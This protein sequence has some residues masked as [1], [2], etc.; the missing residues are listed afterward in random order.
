MGWA[1]IWTLSPINPSFLAKNLT[2]CYVF[3]SF[4]SP[5]KTK[6]LLFR[7]G[8]PHCG[9]DSVPFPSIPFQ[10]CSGIFSRS[11]C[12]FS[13]CPLALQPTVAEPDGAAKLR[14]RRCRPRGSF[15]GD[16]WVWPFCS[17]KSF[18]QMSQNLPQG[19]KFLL[20]SPRQSSINSLRNDCG[21]VFLNSTVEGKQATIIKSQY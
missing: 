9:R 5:T 13:N 4:F 15:L 6:S 8:L 19:Q 20:T 11:L 14:C 1:N 7:Q 17:G 16:R 10:A 2:T 12:L 21:R 3:F 18:G